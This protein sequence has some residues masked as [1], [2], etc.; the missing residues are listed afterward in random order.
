MVL[1]VCRTLVI[2]RLSELAGAGGPPEGGHAGSD[3]AHGACVQGFR[4]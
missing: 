1:L 3:E 4:V 2:P